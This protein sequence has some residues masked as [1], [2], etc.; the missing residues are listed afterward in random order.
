MSGSRSTASQVSGETSDPEKKQIRKI[1]RRVWH[2]VLLAIL[3]ILYLTL[4]L[5][6]IQ[7]FDFLEGSHDDI[8][9]GNSFK[10]SI[11]LSGL[12][13]LFCAYMII[14]HRR[15]VQLTR[16]LIRQKESRMQLSE[17]LQTL[18]ALFDVSHSINSQHRLSDILSTITKEMLSC[19]HADHSSIML[20][21]KRTRMLKTM[22]STGKRAE[23]AED[24]LV[25]LGTSIAGQVVKS[26]EPLLLQGRVNPA[27]FPGFHKKDK[28]ISSALCVPLKIGNSSIGVLNV[29]LLDG[30]RTFS[31]TDLRLISI[32]ANNAAV[33]INNSLL[34]KEKVKRL[35]IQ[36][37]AERLHSPAIIREMVKQSNGGTGSRQIREKLKMSILFAD[38]RGFS[39]MVNTTDLEEVTDF[40][41]N[42]YSDMD[43]AV[44]KNGG[45]TDKFIGDE[46]MAFFGAPNILDNSAE[47]CAKT[48]KEMITSFNRLKARFSQKASFFNHLGVGVGINIGDVFVGQVG[49]SKRF[50]YTVIGQSVNLAR[51]L[52]ESAEPGQILTTAE[53]VHML[54]G[55][56]ASSFMATMSFKGIS[57]TTEVYRID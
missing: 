33:A 7:F 54:N 10:F 20:L 30:R 44:S 41:D 32:F 11:F 37:V 49:S 48:A 27:E 29:N 17:D 8:F 23:T 6:F 35:Q 2:L 36:T 4:S 52:C 31:E 43:A 12:V 3:V 42:F 56:V 24:A 21:D 1:E 40:L 18:G 13:L 53:T 14:Y 19:F 5:I 15:L 38:I 25:P 57:G 55:T 51:R 46:V 45:N 28:T 16:D 39:S 50:D 34:L 26:G 22:I 47:S 9:T